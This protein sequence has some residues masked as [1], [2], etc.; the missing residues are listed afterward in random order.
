M[1]VC[2]ELAATIVENGVVRQ[3]TDAELASAEVSEGSRG[4]GSRWTVRV[5]VLQRSASAPC[6][7]QQGSR[8]AVSGALPPTGTPLPTPPPLHPPQKKGLSATILMEEYLDGPEVDVDLV[9]SSGEPVYGAVTDNWP[10]IEPYFNETGSNTPSILP[11]YQQRE[12][13]D[14]A[15]Q[16]C[17][18]LGLTMVRAGGRTLG[19]VCVGGCGC[20]LW[21]GGGG[22]GGVV[23]CCMT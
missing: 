19:G 9:F 22:L 12:L 13:L 5:L 10:T 7:H 11:S 4:R 3:A 18:A 8:S 17:K 21:C 16:S 1:Q 6:T 23:R 20:V 15:V 14:L 2:R